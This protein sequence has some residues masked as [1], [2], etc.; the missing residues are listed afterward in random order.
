MH[1]SASVPFY[2]IFLAFSSTHELEKANQLAT[3]MLKREDWLV[4]LWVSASNIS[5]PHNKISNNRAGCVCFW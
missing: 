1:I 4:Q 5:N 2:L 3:F